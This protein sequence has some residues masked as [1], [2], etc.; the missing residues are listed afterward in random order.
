MPK[1]SLFSQREKRLLTSPEQAEVERKSRQAGRQTSGSGTESEWEKE[2]KNLRGGGG[3]KG[4]WCLS[5][6]RHLMKD[7]ERFHLQ[8]TTYNNQPLKTKNLGRDHKAR[9][10]RGVGAAENSQLCLWMT[11]LQLCSS[12]HLYLALAD[13]CVSSVPG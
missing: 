6:K 12:I 1:H 5:R 2:K 11:S 7:S 4:L 3:A 9:K 8:L 13:K 10:E